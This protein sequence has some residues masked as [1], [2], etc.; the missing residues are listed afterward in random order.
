VY[1]L[2]PLALIGGAALGFLARGSQTKTV[3]VIQIETTQ[4]PPP[5]THV[6]DV[7]VQPKGGGCLTTDPAYANTNIAQHGWTLRRPGNGSSEGDVVAVAESAGYA[8]CNLSLVFKINPNLGFFVVNDEEGGQWGPFDSH[9][10]A[11]RKWS[12]VLDESS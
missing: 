7:T 5:A 4:A 10:L 6:L 3:T 12:L 2:I 1:T 8:A 9:Q 11:S